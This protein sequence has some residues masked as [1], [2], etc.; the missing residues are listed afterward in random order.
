MYAITKL[1]NGKWH[2]SLMLQDGY[3]EWD[4]D[5]REKAVQSL[6]SGANYGNH[7]FIR[8]DMINFYEEP[9]KTPNLVSDEDF[10]LLM[11]LKSKRKIALDFDDY[12]LKYNLSENECKMVQDI[13]EGRKSILSR[14]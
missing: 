13:R 8:E 2:C 14:G 6:I 10:Q 1:Q 7:D 4:E 11:D 12:R 5:T 9:P 3:E